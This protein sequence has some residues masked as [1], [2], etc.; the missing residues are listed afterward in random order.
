MSSL[1]LP[2][3]S[4]LLLFMLLLLIN[5]HRIVANEYY[6]QEHTYLHSLHLWYQLLLP[7]RPHAPTTPTDVVISHHPRMSLFT[8]H[9]SPSPSCPLSLSSPLP[10][11]VAEINLTIVGM[12]SANWYWQRGDTKQPFTREKGTTL[13][14]LS[15]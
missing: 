8:Q 14:F 2:F 9:I 13:L 11:V 1:S 15:S 3:C 10:V 7:G 5:V 4:P 12:T 6:Y